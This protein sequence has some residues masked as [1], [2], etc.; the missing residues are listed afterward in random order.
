VRWRCSTS[1]CSAGQALSGQGVHEI[2]I[3]VVEARLARFVHRMHGLGGGVD[4]AEPP[5]HGVIETLHAETQAIDARGAIAVHASVFDGAWIGL[6]GDFVRACERQPRFYPLQN[7]SDGIRRKQ[8]G[9]AAAEKDAAERA[10]PDGAA[11]IREILVEISKQGGDIG[12]LR[13][14]STRRMR[15]EVA[16]RALLHAPRNVDVQRQGWGDQHSHILGQSQ[17]LRRR[18]CTLRGAGHPRAHAPSQARGN[19]EGDLQ[20]CRGGRCAIVFA[21]CAQAARGGEFVVAAFPGD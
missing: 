12:I 7:A 16:V 2:D 8:A 10:A 6:Q 11:E 20:R 4:A 3:D 19:D 17:E 15:V 13:D 21:Q 18:Q 1:R 9:R 14:G 5:Q